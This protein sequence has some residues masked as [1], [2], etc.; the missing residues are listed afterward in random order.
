MSTKIVAA[1]DRIIT[2]LT[3][4]GEVDVWSSGFQTA[5]K[6]VY[7][8]NFLALAD[9]KMWPALPNRCLLACTWCIAP[10]QW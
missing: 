3:D 2:R 9:F 5:L 4:G 6:G 10:V 8:S 7:L 1:L